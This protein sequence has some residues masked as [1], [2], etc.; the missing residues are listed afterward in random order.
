MAAAAGQD[1]KGNVFISY[2]RNVVFCQRG[3]LTVFYRHDKDG[4]RFIY[5]V[6]AHY[7]SNGR[8]TRAAM[9]PGSVTNAS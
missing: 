5:H 6:M 7:G 4:R 8:T 1:A 2:S 3:H 9:S